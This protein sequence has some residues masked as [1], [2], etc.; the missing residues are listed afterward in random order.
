MILLRLCA[1][2]SKNGH[3]NV[4]ALI[5]VAT[6]AIVVAICV[7][8]RFLPCKC[9][10]PQCGKVKILDPFHICGVGGPL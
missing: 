2:R 10:T 9:D 5:T 7:H 6:F 8:L 1:I 3:V 4:M